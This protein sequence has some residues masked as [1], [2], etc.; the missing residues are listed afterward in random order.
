MD[1]AIL[2]SGNVAYHY[3][4][5]LHMLGHNIDQIFSKTSANASALAD[6][7]SA[8]AI[9]A[10]ADLNPQLDLYII[11][12]KDDAIADVVADLDANLRGIVV[13]TSGATPITVLDK[14]SN[15]GVLY[16]PQSLNK[17][18][19]IDYSTVHFAVEGNSEEV[20]YL[21]LKLMLTLS[22]TSFRC[23]SAQRLALHVAA[24]FANNFPN[25]LYRLAKSIVEK[26]NLDFSLLKP[27]ILETAEKVQNIDPNQVQTGPA[28]RNDEVTIHR[29][30][31]FLSYSNDLAEIYQTLT[32][33]II[34]SKGKRGNN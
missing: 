12:V 13:H 6:V 30:L 5:A 16:P 15:Y 14:F 8:Q 22:P 28:Q 9:S 17:E 29:H 25:M 11:A 27:L 3:A 34:K 23:T 1:I 31:D 18:L 33:I 19:A 7:V 21:L 32:N 24:V 20:E 2:G 10:L 4:T 26:E